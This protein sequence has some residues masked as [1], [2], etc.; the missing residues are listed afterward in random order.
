MNLLF[1][2]GGNMSGALLAGLNRQGVELRHIAVVEPN[3]DARSRLIE[4][5]SIQVLPEL[6]ADAVA[7]AQVVV[8]AVKPQQL[9]PVAQQLAPWLSGQLVL[10]I[11]AG[12]RSNTLSG[13]LEGYAAVVRAMP[14]PPATVG[15]GVTGLYAADAVTQEQ[16]AAAERIMQ[17]AGDTY[18]FAEEAM[19]DAVTAVSGS[20][21]AYVFYFMEAMQQAAVRMGLPEDVARALTLQTFAGAAKLAQSSAEPVNI[22]RQR[23]TSPGG[24]TEC[25]LLSMETSDVAAAIERAIAAARQRSEELGDALA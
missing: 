23:V 16:R 5:W 7:A 25:A 2:G 18:W 3:A 22:L 9:K 6:A 17:A 20:G 4:A 8:L 11:A 14:N 19:L 10:S 15:A 1:V 12:V 21:P 24:T 13:W